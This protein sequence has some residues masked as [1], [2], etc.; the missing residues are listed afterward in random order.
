MPTSRRNSSHP[1][2]YSWVECMHPLCSG[3]TAANEPECGGVPNQYLSPKYQQR[4]EEE[5]KEAAA[6]LTAKGLN[7]THDVGLGNKSRLA[8]CS[9]HFEPPQCASKMTLSITTCT[10]CCCREGLSDSRLDHILLGLG[11]DQSPLKRCAAWFGGVDTVIRVVIS[12]Y[13]MALAT[14]S[15]SR[16]C[17]RASPGPSMCAGEGMCNS[18]WKVATVQNGVSK[19]RISEDNT[20]EQP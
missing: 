15:Y 17:F 14:G 1:R 9:E 11:N 19:A 20:Q 8:V 16:V 6:L 3:T 7:G 13:R 4:H 2:F 10:T 18:A 12:L 5:K